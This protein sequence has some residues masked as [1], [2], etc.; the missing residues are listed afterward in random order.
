MPALP[1]QSRRN[2]NHNLLK[3]NN[4]LRYTS[5]QGFT[6]HYR[7]F[8]PKGTLI[9]RCSQNLGPK[10]PLVLLECYL[11]M[12]AVIKIC[13]PVFLWVGPKYELPVPW[14]RTVL[15][16]TVPYA[17][18]RTVRY[19]TVRYVGTSTVDS[20]GTVPYTVDS[21]GTTTYHGTVTI[22]EP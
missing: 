3:M 22:L 17:P 4:H 13:A 14:Y 18:H 9:L 15:R 8:G 16:Y 19:G 5:G 2:H 1:V 10:V 7:G 20:T 11:N 21:T 6:T 12:H